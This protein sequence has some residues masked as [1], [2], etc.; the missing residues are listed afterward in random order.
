MKNKIFIII[1]SFVPFLIIQAQTDTVSS[2][3]ISKMN[4]YR[5]SKNMHALKKLRQIN[6]AAKFLSDNETFN[7]DQLNYD[8][9]R[10]FLRMR[11][12][13][14]YQVKV[15]LNN[16]LSNDLDTQVKETIIDS[17]YNL[18]GSYFNG[19]KLLIIFLK[20][21]IQWHSLQMDSLSGYY[22]D[23]FHKS[24]KIVKHGYHVQF[25][26]TLPEVKYVLLENLNDLDKIKN[27]ISI[28]P[29]NGLIELR[30]LSYKNPYVVFFNSNS[31]IIY[32]YEQH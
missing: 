20:S 6:E 3:F 8:S 4:E 15:I 30:K 23:D 21:Y 5:Q 29:H 18:T 14:D 32:I 1:L 12:I 31:Q 10:T 26:T 28:I 16:G 11:H 22:M 2:K 17:S 24:S 27:Y 7:Q 9:I 25:Q 19:N 13:Y